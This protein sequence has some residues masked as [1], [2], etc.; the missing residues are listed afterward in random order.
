M[1][2]VKNSII[3]LEKLSLTIS[4]SNNLA[5]EVAKKIHNTCPIIYGSENLGWVVALRVR[6]QLAENSKMLSFHHHF[7]EQNHNEI[8]GWTKNENIM[9]Q[10][11]IIWINDEDDH[12]E[13]KLRMEITSSLLKSVSGEHVIISQSGENRIERLLK[14]IHFMDWVSYFAALLNKVDPTPVNRIQELKNKITKIV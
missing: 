10:F 2:D 9:I 3:P 8:E 1:N 6:G 7:P 4:Q 14:L 13:T 5:F 11:P 12:L